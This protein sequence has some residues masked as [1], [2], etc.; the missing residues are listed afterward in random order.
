MTSNSGMMCAG[1]KK[2]APTMRSGDLI[3][4]A[5]L[6]MSMV[7]VL[8]DRMQSGRHAASRSA[9]ILCFSSRFSI[10]ASM[11][12]PTLPNSAYVSVGCTSASV[13][14]AFSGVMRPFL[15]LL[16]RLD[17][18]RSMPASRNFWL[19]SLSMTDTP[20]R[21]H[22]VAMPLPMR[23]PP[24]TPTHLVGRGFSPVS[25]TPGT[26]VVPRLAKKKCTSPR[27]AVDDTALANDAC[28]T[29]RP[30]SAPLARPAS[31]ASK[32]SPGCGITDCTAL[33][34]LRAMPSITLAAAGAG[35]LS[36]R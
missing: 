35:S 3:L 18:M 6:V 23:P 31:M 30:S 14:A 5:T 4:A 11:A 34:C 17:L 36:A 27:H 9:K 16:A 29:S 20:L 7:D 13:C 12:M 28:S 10:T 33:A 24:I 25:V 32:H 21:M 26:E 2:C 1:E 22:A 8:V 15:T 19:I